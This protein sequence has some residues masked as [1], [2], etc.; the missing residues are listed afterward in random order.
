MSVFR[1]ITSVDVLRN[2][3]NDVEWADS[4]LILKNLTQAQVVVCTG[5]HVLVADNLAEA[6]FVIAEDVAA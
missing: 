3:L 6:A 5:L 2:D 1:L 4:S